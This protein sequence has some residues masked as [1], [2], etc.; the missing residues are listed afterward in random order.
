VTDALNDAI[1]GH[2]DSP[3]TGARLSLGQV[4]VA[5]W[6]FDESGPLEAA[7]LLVGDGPGRPVRLGEARD[8][9]G[10]AF[11]GVP[12]AAETGFHSVVDLRP[13]TGSATV[14]IALLVQT[15]A[16][17]W[18]EAAA[19]EVGTEAAARS[20]LPGRSRA[21]FTIVKNEPVM[22]PVW[23]DYYSR[24]FDPDDLY[25]LDH[26]SSDG[27]TS[28]LE[29]RCRVVPIH[30]GV[31]FDHRWLHSTVESFQAFLLSSYETVLFAE[32]DEL[33]VADP[34]RYD[35]LDVYIDRLDRPAA[36]CSGFNVVQ[37]PD[38]PP[39]RFDAPLLAQRRH[40]HASNMYSKRLLAR[41]PLRWSD[42]FHYE[43]SAPDDPPDPA[44]LLVHLHRIDYDACLARHR[45]SST[46]KWSEDDFLRGL[47]VQHR[48]T[49]PD[50]FARWF[51]E[52]PDLD[53][54]D[55]LIPEQVR[56][57]V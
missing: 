34:R 12:H 49:D 51:H 23:L 45:A 30:R 42:G 52:G 48:I 35:G 10:R 54:P 18:V 22:L 5:G 13:A 2:I 21:A 14:R 8:D 39:L 29:G 38:E 57:L 7:L 31:A 1:R 55:E 9:V 46:H 43:Y 50:E 20:R 40:W 37:K 44:L 27:S 53:T 24:Y 28:G 19:I 25:V 32:A 4:G 56:A 36:R 6:A 33:V 47:G 3:A 41:M 17:G 26:D 16:R 15:V 11:P